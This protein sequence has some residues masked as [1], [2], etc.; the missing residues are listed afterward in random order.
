MSL[1]AS[2]KTVANSASFMLK[3]RAPEIL[4]VLGVAGSITS[5]VLACKATLNLEDIIDDTKDNLDKAKKLHNG[6]LKLK[7]GASFD[8][9]EYNKF[10]AQT[11]AG[12]AGRL[13]RIYAPSIVLGGLSIA[14]FVTSYKIMMK[15]YIAVGA[16]YAT[17]KKLFDE[18][19]AR[20]VDKYGADE[21]KQLMLGTSTMKVKEKV[22]DEGSGKA[23]TITKEIEVAG[24][25][26]PLDRTLT[27]IFCKDTSTE[28]VPD[29]EYNYSKLMGEQQLANCDLTAN[30][31]V[32]LNDVRDRLG[33]P[34]TK[35][36]YR[37]GWK[38]EKDNPDGDNAIDFGIR[39]IH[40]WDKDISPD[41]KNIFDKDKY[42]NT[43]YA[44]EFNCDGDVW[45]DWDRELNEW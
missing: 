25:E 34:K 42:C 21:D 6:E 45:E 1:L 43:L 26:T 35:A 29:A 4:V 3:K 20:V 28:W 16:A 17:T 24:D 32:I 33:L 19:R 41:V 2:I 36:G 23:K 37:F 15:R 39:E 10:V 9:N 12:C 14:S 27:V 30:G 7:E 44:L 5:T 18:Y 13:L 38:F 8:D 22:I 11:Y 40:S 31:R